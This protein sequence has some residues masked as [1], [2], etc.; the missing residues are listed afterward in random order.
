MPTAGV[1]L[2]GILNVTTDSFSDGNRWMEPAAALDHAAAMRAAGA[3]AIDVGAASSHPAAQP[4]SAEEEILRLSRVLPGLCAAGTP[5][6]VDSWQPAVQ[7]YAIKAGASWINDIR[8]F[9]DACMH[10]ELADSG[11]GLVVMHSVAG[12]SRAVRIATGGEAVW[13]G[14]LR[15]FDERVAALVRAGVRKDR[16]VLDPGMGMF[17]GSGAEPS[18]FVLGRL[19]LL[20]ERYGLPVLVSV[21][22]KSFLGSLTGRQADRRGAASLAAELLAV[23]AGAGFVRTH[24]PGAVRDA[25]LVREALRGH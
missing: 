25:L 2:F 18:L 24:D 10:G 3:D 17:L 23:E 8:G 20:R 19:G 11:V 7:R 22:R 14:I 13:D 15:F 6:S 5:V 9:P 1:T 21:S 4:V 12:G 16:I